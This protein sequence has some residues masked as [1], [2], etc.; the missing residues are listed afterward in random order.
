MKQKRLRNLKIIYIT[1]LITCTEIIY[2]VS[3]VFLYELN[4]HF[5][6]DLP[7]MLK[8]FTEDESA[9]GLWEYKDKKRLKMLYAVMFFYYFP[10]SFT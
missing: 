9:V 10:S 2:E 6:G 7:E 8:Y 5:V 4:I 3:T 1:N